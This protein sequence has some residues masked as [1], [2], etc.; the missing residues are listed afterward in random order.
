ML[1][2]GLSNGNCL[3]AMT[4]LGYS[5]AVGDSTWPHLRNDAAPYHMLRT[6]FDSSNWSGFKIMARWAT[7][8]CCSARAVPCQLH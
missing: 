2:P 4:E 1:S 7:G 6:T 3:K 5:A 8:E